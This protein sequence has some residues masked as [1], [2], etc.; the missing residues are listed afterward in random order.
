MKSLIIA[1]AAA[2]LVAP[3]AHAADSPVMVCMSAPRVA[4]DDSPP[5]ITNL[6]DGLVQQVN[7]FLSG[8]LIQTKEL[9]SR[10]AVQ[11]RAEAVQQKCTYLLNM[12][13]THHPNSRIGRNT[14]ETAMDVGDVARSYGHVPVPARAND[15]LGAARALGGI[16][17]RKESRSSSR[18]SAGGSFYPIGKNDRVEIQYSLERVADK[19]VAKTAEHKAKASK[20]NQPLVEAMLEEIAGEVLEVVVP[21][22]S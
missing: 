7:G 16:L 21:P 2:V 14:A 19:S 10:V 4:V 3:A 17:D 5:A 8:P 12:T 15:A 6:S 9:Q 22:P 20:D 18:S 11:A 13:F 1:L